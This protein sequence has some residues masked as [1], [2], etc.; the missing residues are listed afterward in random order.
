MDL[1]PHLATRQFGRNF[2]FLTE[3]DST[4]K[5][6][7][8]LA[9]QGFPEGMVVCAD[10][11]TAGRGRQNRAWFSPSG[12][13]LYVSLV[14]RPSRP[15]QEAVQVALVGGLA[16]AAALQLSAEVENAVIVTIICDR[17]DRYLS[18]GLFAQ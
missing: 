12:S 17:G 10:R 5:V 11:Q 14:L 13:N 6:A 15:A 4:N 1:A 7:M 18:T 9:S 8:E 2:I 16:V 3:V